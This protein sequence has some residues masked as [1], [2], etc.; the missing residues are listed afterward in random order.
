MLP[1]FGCWILPRTLVPAS[2]G[3]SGWPYEDRAP[4]PG[5]RELEGVEPSVA[6]LTPDAPVINTLSD[7]ARVP[8]R[9]GRAGGAGFGFRWALGGR[10]GSRDGFGTGGSRGRGLSFG[11][12]AEVV[13]SMGPWLPDRARV[14]PAVGCEDCGSPLWV[15]VMGATYSTWTVLRLLSF[16]CLMMAASDSGSIVPC[17]V[18]RPPIACVTTAFLDDSRT[19]AAAAQQ[20]VVSHVVGRG[21]DVLDVAG[22]RGGARDELHHVGRTR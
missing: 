8:S 2:A 11:E 22:R 9:F 4:A 7:A 6:G 17:L 5:P 19:E 13:T 20:R 21:R 15:W 3:G 1:P 18:V 16:C 10:L 12:A 14:L